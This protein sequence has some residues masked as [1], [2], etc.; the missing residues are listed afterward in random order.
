M[1]EELTPSQIEEAKFKLSKVLVHTITSEPFYATLLLQTKPQLSTMLPTAWVNMR[2][3]I[4]F[5]PAF[6]LKHS[7]DELIGVA[8]HE[9]LHKV[10]FH[11]VRLNDRNPKKWNVACDAIINDII[12]RKQGYKLP[13]GGVMFP[14]EKVEGK[15][16]DE[17]YAE[18]PEDPGGGGWDGDGDMKNDGQQPTEADVLDIKR[19]VASAVDNAKRMGK[20][21]AGLDR[22]LGELFEPKQDWKNLM[23]EALTS[24]LM[25]NDLFTYTKNSHTGRAAG[26]VL[27]ALSR[28]VAMRRVVIGIDTS[29]SIDE[30]QLLTFVSEVRGILH[31]IGIQETHV[32][33]CD[34]DIHDVHILPDF[35]KDYT[36]A[37]V[38]GGG[39]TSFQPVFD[40]AEEHEAEAV[41][42]FTDMY[43]SFPEQ[44]DYTVVWAATTDIVGPYG[45]TVKI[46]V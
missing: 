12:V 41:I 20:M 35:E 42:Y 14:P 4:F 34:A 9:V 37:K 23:E 13:A 39:G 11:V 16:A 33:Y 6:V 18:L 36:P 29:G 1:N 32:V 38:G 25:G 45:A 46:D 8:I 19:Q 21:P 15:T 30:K 27:P 24:A 40:Y 17:V 26:A 5:N 28:S 31:S 43:C 44:P 3:H 10:F 2:G 22:L 7:V